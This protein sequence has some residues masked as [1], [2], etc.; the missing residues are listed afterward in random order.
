M[1]CQASDNKGSAMDIETMSHVDLLNAYDN[2]RR[3]ATGPVPQAFREEIL[4]RMDSACTS[5][6][7][8]IAPHPSE[9]Q[10]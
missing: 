6:R 1:D 7:E 4:R 8:E 2:A 5:R 10:R 3:G 9:Y